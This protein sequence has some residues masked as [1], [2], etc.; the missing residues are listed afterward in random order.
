MFKMIIVPIIRG[1]KLCVIVIAEASLTL[2][3]LKINLLCLAT[4]L[5]DL[6]SGFVLSLIS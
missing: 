3:N 2:K 6:S 1:G 4:G 5:Q